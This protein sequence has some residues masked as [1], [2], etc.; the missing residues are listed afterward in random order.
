MNTLTANR[1]RFVCNLGRAL[2]MRT[3]L[4]GTGASAAS[5]LAVAP[6]SSVAEASRS[7]AA[8]QGW[9]QCVFVWQPISDQTFLKQL[10]DALTKLQ[11]EDNFAL[12]GFIQRLEYERPLM[13]T[14]VFG[15]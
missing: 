10:S 8:E 1:L 3:V 14:L 2:C 15:S 13:S 11:F 9:V 7:G 12:Q 6:S 5:M 4:A